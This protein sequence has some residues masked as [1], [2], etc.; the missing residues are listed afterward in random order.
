MPKI[1][2][3]NPKRMATPLLKRQKPKEKIMEVKTNKPMN[4]RTLGGL[5][6]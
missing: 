5:R 4:K 2:V 1:T 6:K 3:K